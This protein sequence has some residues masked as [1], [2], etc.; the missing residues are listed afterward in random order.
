MHKIF[1]AVASMIVTHFLQKAYRK[2]TE[3][4]T[5]DKDEIYRQMK[6]AEYDARRA[7]ARPVIAKLDS[8]STP[9]DGEKW[10][11][12]IGTIQQM[13]DALSPKTCAVD[14]CDA[15]AMSPRRFS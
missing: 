13:R 12:S 14:G 8:I 7:A 15:M 3:K 6:K 10:M 11:A 4:P 5:I 9:R 2:I 1:L